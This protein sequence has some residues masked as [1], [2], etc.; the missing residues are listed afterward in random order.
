MPIIA[1]QIKFAGSAT[2]KADVNA[3][4]T[5]APL[6]LTWSGARLVN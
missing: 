2:A 4:K 1:D 6:P 5:P 3:V